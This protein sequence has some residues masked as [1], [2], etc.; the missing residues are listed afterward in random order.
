MPQ[1]QPW[2]DGAVGVSQ[3]PIMPGNNFTYKF[4]AWPAGTHYWH[5][6]M[7]GMQ[8][9]KGLRGPFIIK[10]KED[11]NAAMYDEEKVIVLADEWQNP[12]VCLKLEGAM[13][14]NDV[15]SDIEY[16][17]V[18]GQVA[19]GD[20]Q[21]FDKKYPYPLV[22]VEAGKCYRFRYIMMASN[23][24]NYIVRLAG[25]NMTLIALD[26]VDVEPIQITTLNMHIGERADVVVC[27]DQKPGY[28]PME[29]TYDC[30]LEEAWQRAEHVLDTHSALPI[31]PTPHHHPLPPAPYPPPQT[32]AP[33]PRD[34]S[35]L[36][37]S[38]L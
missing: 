5:S 37:G 14:G 38:T 7:D 9:A 2:T 8:S 16:A 6:H 23:A 32:R 11:R 35:S 12:D 19:L 36:P 3:A 26:G 20:L 28:Y 4:R 34:T 29:M 15:C 17:S 21:K 30:E 18:N 22:D 31:A 10:K 24:E 1:D 33:S 13:A 27:A 25:H